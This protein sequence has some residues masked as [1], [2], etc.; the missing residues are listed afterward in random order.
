[1]SSLQTTEPGALSLQTCLDHQV[2]ES[3]ISGLKQVLVV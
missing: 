1:M 2:M 3:F